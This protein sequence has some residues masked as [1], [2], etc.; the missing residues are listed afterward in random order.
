M[1]NVNI[2]NYSKL[3][4]C[5]PSKRDLEWH[6]KVWWIDVLQESSAKLSRELSGHLVGITECPRMANLRCEDQCVM[7]HS[8]I[9]PV[10]RKQDWRNVCEVASIACESERL[11]GDAREKGW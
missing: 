6:K 7:L 4:K 10:N 9:I 1:E 8:S 5:C 11:K 2:N 3:N